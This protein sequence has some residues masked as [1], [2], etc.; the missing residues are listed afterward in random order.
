VVR[1]GLS[2]DRP[3]RAAIISTDVSGPG[4]HVA[5]ELQPAAL[6]DRPDEYRRD[7]RFQPEVVIR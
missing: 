1:I 7:R 3:D 6:P 5:N 2:E 4:E